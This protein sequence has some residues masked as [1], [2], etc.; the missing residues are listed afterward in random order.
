VI[1]PLAAI[2]IKN[3]YEIK[4]VLRTLLGS[5]HFFNTM[6]RGG[7]IKNPVDFL[8]GACRQFKSTIYNSIYK[9]YEAWHHLSVAL[10]D[11]GMRPGDP[12]NIAGWQAYYIPPNFDK[13]WINSDTLVARN[14]T[15]AACFSENG[16]RNQDKSI[17]IIFDVIHF[18]SR[19][20]KPQDIF[21]FID[22][23]TTLL[24]P[25]LF[26]PT[27]KAF[28]RN[29]LV[30]GEFEDSAWSDLWEAFSTEPNN[31]QTRNNVTERL[32]AFYCFMLQKEEYHLL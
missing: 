30:A 10:A 15:I 12:P 5:E 18:A 13:L 24:S 14:Q 11:M 7:Q 31:I 26:D 2:L 19:C 9:Q 23:N 4:P 20:K 8:I 21:H 3:N 6:Y 17:K 29:I 27:E 25:F 32:N 22:E 28:L 16:L 1:A